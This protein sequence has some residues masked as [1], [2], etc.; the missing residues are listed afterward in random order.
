MTIFGKCEE[1]LSSGRNAALATVVDAS[2]GTPGKQ[3]FKLVLAGD[4]EL[5]GTVGGGALEN[6]VIGEAREVLD[7]RRS[8]I[9][10]LD[11]SELK[12]E[13]GGSVDLVIE[14]LT[15]VL[16][17]L[18]FGGGHVARALCPILQALDFGITVFDPRPDTSA[19]FDALNVPV[20]SV[21]YEEIQQHQ[22]LI[23]KAEYCVIA[24]HG[25]QH[26]F[27]VLKQL[28]ELESGLRYIGLI[29]S[30]RKVKVT[31]SRLEQDGLAIP[32]AVYSPIGLKIGARTASEIAVSIAAEVVA[33]KNGHPADHMRLND[34]P[35]K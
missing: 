4:G 29:G 15:G 1:I 7:S 34:P 9:L 14:Y 28:I 31:L 21:G 20:V 3:G 35:Q 5:F 33:I 12:M 11:L 25:H 30:S 27:H 10:H 17:F 22:E 24:T 23:G 26:D 18:L 2:S 6:R 8:R 16:P 32:S 13:C 19:Y